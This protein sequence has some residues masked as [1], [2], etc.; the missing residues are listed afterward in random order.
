MVAPGANIQ[1]ETTDISGA[2]DIIKCA[3]AIILQLE[4]SLDIVEFTISLANKY[5]IPVVLNS[6]PAQKLNKDILENIQILIANETESSILT[7][8]KIIRTEDVELVAKSLFDMGISIVI[9]TLGEKGTFFL[10][11]DYKGLIPAFPVDPIDTT[12]AGDAFIGAFAAAYIKGK[13]IKD[14]VLI[15]NAAGALTVTNLGT[16]ASFPSLEE[17]KIF[18]KRY[19]FYASPSKH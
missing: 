9:L 7:G 5:S 14:A 6:A 13:S 4:I 19:K 12:G 18:L 8:L 3:D 16:Q 15:G 10:T 1:L 11:S 17:I 2:K